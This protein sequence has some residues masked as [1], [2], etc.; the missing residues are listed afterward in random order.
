MTD[1]RPG[2]L[3]EIAM[4]AGIE[5]A[6]FVN[7]AADQLRPLPASQP[8]PHPRARRHGAARRRPGL[9]LR[10]ARPDV[11][12]AEPV[13]RTRRPASGAPRPRSSRVPSELV[14]LYNPARAVRLVRR[15]R[16]CGGRPA[17]RAD[18]RPGPARRVGHRV[19]E[20]HRRR[21]RR[22]RPVHRCRRRVGRGPG[23]RHRP[24]TQARPPAACTTWRSRSRS[25]ASCP[26][27]ASSSSSRSRPQP[28]A[29]RARR[30][31][32]SWMTRTSDCGSRASGAFEAEVIPERDE[33]D[34]QEGQWVALQSPRGAGPVLRPDRPVR[35]PRRDARRAVPRGRPGGRRRRC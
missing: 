23:R 18:R 3:G 22:Q 26:R 2:I 28:L 14:E 32:A 34:E 7:D 25:A 6:S 11:P 10:R 8:R 15:G 12:L 5:R 9:P 4:E 21:H 20:W 19:R 16:P 1:P 35:R 29:G 30:P 33:D 24:P 27:H 31:A 13:R 17:R